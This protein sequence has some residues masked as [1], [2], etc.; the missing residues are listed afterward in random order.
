MKQQRR[1]PV[2]EVSSIFF[3]IVKPAIYLLMVFAFMAIFG[4]IFLP[5]GVDPIFSMVLWFILLAGGT[6]AFCKFTYRRRAQVFRVRESPGEFMEVALYS[7]LG[8]MGAGPVSALLFASIAT[9][10]EPVQPV[11][12]LVAAVAAVLFCLSARSLYKNVNGG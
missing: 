4:G 9:S 11:L 3:G 10:Q 7:L 2:Q 1:S 8:V 5:I 12:V 6:A